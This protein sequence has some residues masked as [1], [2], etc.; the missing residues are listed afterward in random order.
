MSSGN[1]MIGQVV[2]RNT[3]STDVGSKNAFHSAQ[4][5]HGGV[6]TVAGSRFP[7][8]SIAPPIQRICSILLP[9]CGFFCSRVMIGVNGHVTSSVTCPVASVINFSSSASPSGNGGQFLFGGK[10][11]KQ[12]I[13]PSRTQS[14]RYAHGNGFHPR[15]LLRPIGM[16]VRSM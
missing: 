2:L 12:L 9:S 10:L 15:A 6:G 11:F 16:S 4:L 13:A 14:L 7:A 8:T 1:W 3:H 5:F